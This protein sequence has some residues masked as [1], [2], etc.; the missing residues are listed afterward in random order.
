M[1]R[2]GQIVDEG[3]WYCFYKGE[4][5]RG[6]DV[7]VYL[8]PG[9]QLKDCSYC[10]NRVRCDSYRNAGKRRFGWC[11]RYIEPEYWHK[12]RFFIGRTLDSIGYAK[13]VVVK[14][15]EKDFTSWKRK[16]IEE[17]EIGESTELYTNPWWEEDAAYD[18]SDGSPE[19]GEPEEEP[20]GHDGVRAGHPL[21][22]EEASEVGS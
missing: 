21:D 14:Q 15:M 20:Q 10:I 4:W 1:T 8:C 7:V 19:A 16:R 3:F 13:D 18:T 5:L 11:N 6:D 9:F 17:G 2:F 22:S 12:G